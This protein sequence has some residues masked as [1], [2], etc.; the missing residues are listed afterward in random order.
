MSPSN[1]QVQPSSFEEVLPIWQDKLWPGRLAAI[2]PTSA[3]KLLGGYNLEYLR[4][5]A[6]FW[7]LEKNNTILGVI[8]GFLTE[9]KYFRI[10]GIWVDENTRCQGLGSLLFEAVQQKATALNCHTLW[11]MPRA[12]AKGFYSK[13]GMTS[14]G[15]ANEF[16]FGPHNWMVKP[17]NSD[18]SL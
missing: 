7:R 5:T 4:H 3:I 13:M 14:I 15:S 10:R 17:L 2:E 16:E 12:S 11:S 18:C 1:P 8:S 6:F 9:P